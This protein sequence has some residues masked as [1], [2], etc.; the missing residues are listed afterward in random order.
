M[1]KYLLYLI[2]FA[3]VCSFTTSAIAFEITTISGTAQFKSN[4]MAKYMKKH[5]FSFLDEVLYGSK[6]KTNLYAA[7]SAEVLIENKYGSV[8][9][10]GTADSQGK[11][12]FSVP[13]D[14]N[15]KITVKFHNR[16]FKK[17]VAN[18]NAGEYTADL[19]YFD[20]DTVVGWFPARALSYCYECRIRYLENIEASL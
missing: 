6:Y 19:G 18:K 13:K 11:F 2:V 4:L 8:L 5:G 16:I 12:S 14:N 10:E 7:K 15:Y 20:S 1:R 17:E 3:V 9:A